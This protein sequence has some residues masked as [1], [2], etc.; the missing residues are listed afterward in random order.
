MCQTF[1]Y[2][3]SL[4]YSELPDK[5]NTIFLKVRIEARRRVNWVKTTQKECISIF[6]FTRTFVCWYASKGSLFCFCLSTRITNPGPLLFFRCKNDNYIWKFG[7]VT[8]VN[9]P[10][11]TRLQPSALPYYFEIIPSSL[12]LHPLSPFNRPNELTGQRTGS[13]VNIILTSWKGSQAVGVGV[14]GVRNPT[15]MANKQKEERETPIWRMRPFTGG[16]VSGAGQI[17]RLDL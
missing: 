9:H 11:I 16:E 14:G 8:K 4:Y 7:E 15:P 10:I 1:V 5:I 2:L 13:A 6:H 12:F 3:L 17:E